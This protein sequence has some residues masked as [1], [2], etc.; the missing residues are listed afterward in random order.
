MIRFGSD[1]DECLLEVVPLISEEIK[2][3]FKKTVD[4]DSIS[5]YDMCE[6][7]GL[8]ENDMRTAID[9]AINRTDD[10]RAVP[11]AMETLTWLAPL[12]KSPIPLIT[13]RPIRHYIATMRT[14]NRIIPKDAKWTL[15]M[16]DTPFSKSHDKVP[17]IV[18]QRVDIFVE[19]RARY[20]H[21]IAGH[22]D[23]TVLLL[24]RPWNRH[25][26]SSKNVLRME[27]WLHVRE[28]MEKIL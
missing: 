28:F 14:L 20:A 10:I 15:H 5:R 6:A 8:G 2:F 9:A 18:S 23:C 16:T 26:E 12:V 27:N 4:I 22:T 24:D 3:R 13:T 1:I 19:D 17:Q 21:E 11:H 7:T 25:G